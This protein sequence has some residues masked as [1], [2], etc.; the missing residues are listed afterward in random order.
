MS[1][2]VTVDATVRVRFS[3]LMEN[4]EGGVAELR[5]ILPACRLVRPCF[6]RRTWL[7]RLRND[8]APHDAATVTEVFDVHSGPTT[9]GGGE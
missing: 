5:A 7:Q 4:V 6:W 9:Y 1:I 2:F 3:I 8:S